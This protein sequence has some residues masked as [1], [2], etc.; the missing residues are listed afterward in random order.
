MTN[1]NNNLPT[2]ATEGVQEMDN[3]FKSLEHPLFSCVIGSY[4]QLHVLPKVMAGWEKVRCPDGFEVFLCDDHSSDGTKEWAEEYAKRTDLKFKFTYLRIKK[5]VEPG[6]LATNLN[7]AMPLA[8][9]HY[10]FFCMG[11]S[12]PEEDVLIKFAKN[13]G[14]GRVLCGIRKN[15]DEKGNFLSWD[16]R[17]QDPEQ[18]MAHEVIPIMDDCPWAAI[19]G[20]GL[21]VPTWALKEVGGWNDD[22]HGWEDDD[23][24]LALR[25]YEHNLEFYHVPNAIIDH[26]EHPTQ[27]RSLANVEIFKKLVASYKEKVRNGLESITLEFDDFYPG[28]DGLFFLDELHNHY[29]EMKVS[30]FAVPLKITDEGGLVSWETNKDFVEEVNSRP[31]L[32]ILPHGFF[33]IRKEYENWTYEKTM[34]AIKAWESLFTSLKMNWKKVTRAPHWEYGTEALRAFRDSGYIVAIDPSARNK[35]TLPDGLKIYE[36]NWGVQFPLPNKTVLKGHGHIQDWNGTGI[37]ENL[38]N[39]LDLPV[40]KT[41]KFVSELPYETIHSENDKLINTIKE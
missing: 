10:T 29:P 7:Q 17:M 19:T 8:Q 11:D 36:H 16:W 25:L 37:G 27:P 21:V 5:R 24:D 3:W 28:N 33:H 20:N 14:P 30:L 6:G 18:F 9:G 2:G 26:I 31:W 22:Y 23:Y 1:T 12:I 40:G 41:W 34:I 15:V 35:M 4:N 38:A 39:L 13:V 32:E